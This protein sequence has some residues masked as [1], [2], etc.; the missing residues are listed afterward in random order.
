APFAFGSAAGCEHSLEVLGHHLA[1]PFDGVVPVGQQPV[2]D[3][4]FGLLVVPADAVVEELAVVLVDRVQVHH[5][6][7]DPVG[8]QIQ[9]VG[10]TTGHAGREVAPDGA[11]EHGPTT[12][13]VLATVVTGAFDHRDGPGVAH[14]EPQ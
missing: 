8:V 7:V 4:G 5:F 14:A 2:R 11:E 10:D 12:G 6:P 1:E 3:R 9:H 13:H